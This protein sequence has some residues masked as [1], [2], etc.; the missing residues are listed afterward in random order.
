MC[1]KKI[2]A[3][4]HALTYLAYVAFEGTLARFSVLDFLSVNTDT[5][6]SINSMMWVRSGEKMYPSKEVVGSS[7]LGTRTASFDKKVDSWAFGS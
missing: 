5:I 6:A 3:Y 7:N 2:S 4:Y 1:K